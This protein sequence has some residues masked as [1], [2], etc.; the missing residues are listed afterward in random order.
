MSVSRKTP[1]TL[2]AWTRPARIV[3]HGRA[4]SALA[5]MTEGFRASRGTVIVPRVSTFA[6]TASADVTI[7]A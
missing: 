2:G 7:V 3:S 1:E 4:Q 6:S 5:P